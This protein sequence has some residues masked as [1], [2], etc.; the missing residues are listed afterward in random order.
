M[1]EKN[2]QPDY[3]RAEFQHRSG[4]RC[5]RQSNNMQ[6]ACSIARIYSMTTS[7]LLHHCLSEICNQVIST[8]DTNTEYCS[9]QRL[10]LI[11]AHMY[12]IYIIY[13]C[14]EH[15]PESGPKR[16]SAACFSLSSVLT[17]ITNTIL[18][19]IQVNCKSRKPLSTWAAT[20][21]ENGPSDSPAQS[22]P[23]PGRFDLAT[24]Q[25]LWRE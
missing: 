12:H 16:F 5:T 10:I 14:S 21:L 15:S 1:K 9:I 25:S 11:T 4:Q 6:Q 17:I 24:V 22:L 20:D 3:P 13:R 19:L 8:V 23:G 2:P 18:P 7:I